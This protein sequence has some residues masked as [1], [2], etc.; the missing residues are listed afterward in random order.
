MDLTPQVTGHVVRKAAEYIKTYGWRQRTFGSIHTGF[1]ML[2]AI[3]EACVRDL[4]VGD[5]MSRINTY[6]TMSDGIGEWLVN[7]NGGVRYTNSPIPA[8]NATFF[9]DVRGR[10]QEEI[11]L[12]M[13]KYADEVDPQVVPE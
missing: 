7:L 8:G 11:L 4:V 9:N 13:T 6:S 5:E 10:T 12:H 1:C 2:G 3:R